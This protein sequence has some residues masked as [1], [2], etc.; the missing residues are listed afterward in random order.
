MDSKFL[1]ILHLIQQSQNN[2]V[3]AVNIELINL[4]CY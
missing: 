3:K 2:A 4:Y 1:D